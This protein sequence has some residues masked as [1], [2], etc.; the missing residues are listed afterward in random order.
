MFSK[1]VLHL[2]VIVCPC[3]QEGT[4]CFCSSWF[5]TNIKAE[6]LGIKD[7]TLKNLDLQIWGEKFHRLS[8]LPLDEVQTALR[9]TAKAAVTCMWCDETCHLLQ[10]WTVKSLICSLLKPADRHIPKRAA[11]QSAD[12]HGERSKT[13]RWSSREK[14]SYLCLS[15]VY[16]PLGNCHGISMSVSEAKFSRKNHVTSGSSEIP[17]RT[18]QWSQRPEG[19]TWNWQRDRTKPYPQQGGGERATRERTGLYPN[20]GNN[21]FYPKSYSGEKRWDLR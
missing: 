2:H 6:K 4:I 5:Y 9:I 17:L 12:K 1:V 7:T 13:P 16:N 10:G 21:I 11:V 15:R 8:P 3:T 19:A 20:I 18:Q 14:T